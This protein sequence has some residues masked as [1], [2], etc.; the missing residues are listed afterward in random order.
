[1]NKIIFL[2]ITLIVIFG[3]NENTALSKDNISNVHDTNVSLD[4][5]NSSS[6]ESNLNSE[7]IEIV[8]IFYPDGNPTSIEISGHYAYLGVHEG[9]SIVDLSSPLEPK[10]VGFTNTNGAISKL[11]ISGDY[12]YL[13]IPYFGMQIVDISNPR[14]PTVIASFEEVTARGIEIVG[15]YAYLSGKVGL[16]ILDISIPTAPTLIGTF[17]SYAAYEVSIHEMNAFLADSKEGFKV[18][19]ISNPSLPVQIASLEIGGYTNSVNIS[20]NYAY[21]TDSKGLKIIDI[22]QPK[23]P[24]IIASIDSNDTKGYL[25]SVRVFGNYAYLSNGTSGLKIIDISTPIEAILIKTIDTYEA[26]E[27][28][29]FNDYIYS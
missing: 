21:I 26:F 4:E 20:G 18:I 24:F 5:G 17:D 8:D 12:A 11:S 2:C 23:E 27:T 6:N 7:S 10:S 19:D 22:S 1:M 3:C 15:K 16:K 29:I 9:L 14:V 13:A 25:Y 28:A